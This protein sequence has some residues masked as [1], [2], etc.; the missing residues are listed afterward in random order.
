MIYLKKKLDETN[1]CPYDFSCLWID[2]SRRC[3]RCAI[4]EVSGETFL[5]LK[6]KGP[7]SCPNCLRWSKGEICRCPT[8]Y[9]LYNRY[10][11]VTRSKNVG[12]LIADENDVIINAN[13]W[14]ERIAG[15]P[16]KSIVGNNF[17]TGFPNQTVRF[18]KPFYEKT[19]KT[20][21]CQRYENISVVT[22]GGRQSCQSGWLIPQ[23][24][25]NTV[26]RMVCTMEDVTESKIFIPSAR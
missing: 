22:P 25:K 26:V 15:I 12:V 11:V 13:T 20:R 2:E 5:F 6:G 17:L 9:A 16:V 24:D 7:S 21:E 14:M 8:N 4:K 23:M 10:S 1:T 3:G 19:K 18:L